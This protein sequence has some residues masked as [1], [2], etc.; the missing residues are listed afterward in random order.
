LRDSS[1]SGALPEWMLGLTKVSATGG[2][3]PS[4]A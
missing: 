1:G 2:S 4:N 3:R